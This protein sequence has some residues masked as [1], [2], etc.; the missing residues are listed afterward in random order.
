MHNNR[1]L[2]LP[3]ATPPRLLDQVRSVIRRKH[4]SYRTEDAYVFWMKRF[5]VFSGKRHPRE[6]GKTHVTAF[7]NH[8]AREQRVAASTQN[9]ALSALLFLH[10]CWTRFELPSARVVT[11]TGPSRLLRAPQS[12][13][14][15]RTGQWV[16]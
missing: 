9:Q 6:L 2:F 13:P 1:E 3:A 10:G 12:S 7:L 4:Y 14:L 15:D 5:I 16:A 8:L 11:A